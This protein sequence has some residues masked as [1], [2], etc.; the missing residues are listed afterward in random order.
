[1]ALRTPE[2]EPPNPP[3]KPKGRM[4]IGKGPAIFFAIAMILLVVIVVDLASPDSSDQQTRPST[5]PA[6]EPTQPSSSTDEDY[7]SS[8][9]GLEES[10][11]T[12]VSSDNRAAS[13]PARSQP[14]EGLRSVAVV[15]TTNSITISWDPVARASGYEIELS[16]SSISCSELSGTRPGIECTALPPETTYTISFRARSA[17]G[18][19]S[20]WTTE[21]VSTLALPVPELPSYVTVLLNER[22]DDIALSAVEAAIAKIVAWYEHEHGLTADFPSMIR[23]EPQCSPTAYLDVLGYATPGKG[24]LGEEVIEVCVRLDEDNDAVLETDQ[25][26]WLVAHEYFHVLQANAGWVFE[27]F[28]LSFAGTG[29]CGKHLVEGAAEY[30]AQLYTW[31]ELRDGGILDDLLSLF[32]DIDYERQYYYEEGAKAFA[33]LIRWKGQTEAT[34]FWESDESRCSD[35][36]LTAFDVTPAKYEA[37]WRELTQ[38]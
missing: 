25:F 30:F 26:R 36:F 6:G 34:R 17:S 16:D 38:R 14:L 9:R 27:D 13:Q 1:M 3:K 22:Y 18:T 35:A 8:S 37:D 33:A 4:S 5:A 29:A 19:F 2:L 21:Q 7:S 12:S 28:E 31:G 10:E 15:A 20:S 32:R 24:P 23:L 11:P